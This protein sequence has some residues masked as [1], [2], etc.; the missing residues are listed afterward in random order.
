VEGAWRAGRGGRV[1]A[2]VRGVRAAGGG[3][4]RPDQLDALPGALDFTL[5][6]PDKTEIDRILAEDITDPIGPEF[7]APPLGVAA[8]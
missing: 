7:M 8:T 4:R 3:A 6:Q 5:D 1:E 2:G